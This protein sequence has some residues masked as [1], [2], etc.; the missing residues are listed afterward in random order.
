MS[1]VMATEELEYTGESVRV[2]YPVTGIKQADEFIG[3]YIEAVGGCR[4]RDGE[5]VEGGYEVSECEQLLS[6]RLEL[7]IC[8]G[9]RVMYIG[10]A[11][12]TID[13]ASGKIIGIREAV[14][15]DPHTGKRLPWHRGGVGAALFPH[16]KS[17]K[18]GGSEGKCSSE[19]AEAHDSAH[20]YRALRRE[21]RALCSE[22]SYAGLLFDGG[23]ELLALKK[24]DPDGNNGTGMRASEARRRIAVKTCTASSVSKQAIT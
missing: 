4:A 23:A 14:M 13:K 7:R 17:R 18:R 15:R 24:E 9:R 16:H 1:G 21:K 10:T 22:Y 8:R 2:R 3:A 19:K 5:R 20:L 6:V 11:G 12:I